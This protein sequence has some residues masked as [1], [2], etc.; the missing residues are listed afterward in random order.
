M[1]RI[2]FLASFTLSS[3]ALACP[4]PPDATRLA[5]EVDHA[6]LAYV[7]MDEPPLS[8]PFAITVTFCH[9]N[10][11][12]E[13]LMFDALMPAHRHGM[14]FTVDVNKIAN[15]RFEVSNIVFHM[16]GLWEIRVKAETARRNYTYTAEVP[17]K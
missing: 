5:P 15:N 11:Q 12:I 6:P 3:G 7:E 2:A 14:N 17:L 13:T 16:P 9:P 4:A 8:A 10:R 1:I